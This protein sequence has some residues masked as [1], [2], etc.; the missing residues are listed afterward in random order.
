MRVSIR[1][2]P[3]VAVLLAAGCSSSAKVSGNGSAVG[4]TPTG[5][6]AA[7]SAAAPGA[8]AGGVLIEP[9]AESNPACKLLTVDEVEQALS[10]TV[11]EIN[12]LSAPGKYSDKAQVCHWVTSG[13][14]VSDAQAVIVVL[15]NDIDLATAKDELATNA[16]SGIGNRTSGLGDEAIDYGGPIEVLKG[17]TWVRV[18]VEVGDLKLDDTGSAALAPLAVARI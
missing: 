16:D 6:S 18:D 13:P 4:V 17:T 3:V 2:V 8:S 5:G 11:H 7:S 15:E 9:G 14:T 1:A 10:M 12:A